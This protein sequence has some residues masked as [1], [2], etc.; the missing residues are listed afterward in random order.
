MY[1][2]HVLQWPS[3][4]DPGATGK[5]LQPGRS[6]QRPCLKL[7]Q[8]TLLTCHVLTSHQVRNDTFHTQVLHTDTV[9]RDLKRVARR[10]ARAAAAAAAGAPE[11]QGM[12]GGDGGLAEEGHDADGAWFSCGCG[13]GCVRG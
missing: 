7:A 12:G 5:A 4:K 9:I 1:K 11:Q 2:T 10:Q 3:S 13:C 8:G 6:Q